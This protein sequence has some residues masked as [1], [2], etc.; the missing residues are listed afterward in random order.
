MMN[1]VPGSA[2]GLLRKDSCQISLPD[3]TGPLSV[4]AVIQ[5][6][7]GGVYSTERNGTKFTKLLRYKPR[8]GTKMVV[9]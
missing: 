7:G 5:E 3:P 2:P 8:N 6:G 9:A 1:S 4:N